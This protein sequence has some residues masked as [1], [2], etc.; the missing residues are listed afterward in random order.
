MWVDAS[1]YF[2]TRNIGE[3]GTKQVLVEEQIPIVIKKVHSK[4]HFYNTGGTIVAGP[5][6]K[7][8]HSVS[9]VTNILKHTLI[10]SFFEDNN[11]SYSDLRC[12]LSEHW[13]E[14]DY[15]DVKHQ[16]QRNKEHKSFIF[17]HGSDNIGFFSTWIAILAMEMNFKAV[18]LVSQR[19]LDKP[20][21]DLLKLCY[22]SLEVLKKLKPSNAIVICSTKQNVECHIPFEIRKYHTTKKDA[23][24]SKHRKVLTVDTC[25]KDTS[26]LFKEPSL[27]SGHPWPK[28]ALENP[29][30]DTVESDIRLCRGSG[31][32][33]KILPNEDLAV[34]IG[35]GP[36][37][38]L[39][40][41]TTANKQSILECS[42]EALY[43][44]KRYLK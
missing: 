1:G 16:L 18:I 17:T 22:A 36:L 5:N 28:V 37:N 19:S 9:P 38:T 23:F 14:Q 33:K 7:D 30:E 11:I 40:Y 25:L 13:T 44:L 35:S 31:N 39:L 20:T 42:W 41:T 8:Y 10:N 21:N 34:I 29:L 4:V 3:L 24:Y 12:K 32:A 2:Y 43:V 27:S 15:I 6:Y 26:K